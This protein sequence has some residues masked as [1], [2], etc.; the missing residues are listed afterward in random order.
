MTMIAAQFGLVSDDNGVLLAAAARGDQASWNELVRKY[1][2]L[3]WSIARGFR[4]S[5]ED[6]SDVVQNTWL[7]LVENLDRINQP[8][9]LAA[10]LGTSAR[11]E[12]LQ[13]LKRNTKTTT[14]E[15]LPELRDP[16]PEVDTSLLVDERDHALWQAVQRLSDKC[17]QLIRVLMA[18]PP[19]SYADV[20]EMLGMPV[21]SIGP[22]RIRCLDKLRK[23]VEKL[24]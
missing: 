21:G 16:A 19:P 6:A 20:A 18:D 1:N 23:Q 5:T 3:L 2:A 24:P 7:R 14:V 11:R 17:Y 10:W 8:D 13:L 12:C 22:N 15:E 9:R 4:L